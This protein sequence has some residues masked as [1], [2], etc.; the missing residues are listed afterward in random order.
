MK[1]TDEPNSA[2][3]GLLVA[4]IRKLPEPVKKIYRANQLAKIRQSGRDMVPYAQDLERAVRFWAS[5]A[6]RRRALEAL[7]RCQ[8]LEEYFDFATKHLGHLQWKQEFLGFLEFAKEMKPVRIG[9]VG[10]FTGGTHLIFAHALPNVQL[11]LGVDMHVR[12]KSQL[13]YFAKSSQKQIFVEGKSCAGA[14]LEKVTRALGD[15]KLDLLLIDA[16]HSYAA[17]KQDFLHYRRFVREGGLIAFHDIVPDYYTKFGRDPAT[18][19][20]SSA[21]EV[22]LFWKNLKPYYENTREF[23]IDYEQ[24][25]C[26]IGTIVYSS[27]VV[28]PEDL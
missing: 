6:E 19:A 23:V 28:I 3:A 22:Y 25:G 1:M 27:N 7:E 16:D 12:N 13:G 20:G 14:T 8:T 15:E 4:L 5:P 9:E 21:G 2:Q 11:T 10:L 18:W 26:G 17:V 24:D